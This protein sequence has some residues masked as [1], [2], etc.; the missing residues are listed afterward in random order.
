MKIFILKPSSLGDIVQ[1]LPVLRLLKL[2]I[3]QSQIY[4]WVDTRF[5]SI[6][7]GDKDL[8]GVIYFDR[9]HW[10]SPYYWGEV[11][12]SILN[13]RKERFD[14]VIDLQGLL[15]SGAFAW[16]ANGELLIGV[17]E[18]REGA[19]GFYDIAVRRPSY[20]THAVDWYLEV[21]KVLDIPVHF[22]FDWLPIRPE[23]A[24]SIKEKWIADSR[25]VVICPGG[26][27]K[28]KRW[29]DQNY[30]SLAKR[31]A[32]EDSDITFVII[33][34]NECFE[35]GEKIREVL[36]DRCINL[37]GKT[38]IPEMIEVIRFSQYVVSNDTGPMHIAAALKKP[39]VAIFGPT[40]PKRTGP[41]GFLQGVVQAS[42]PC[43]PCFKR[44]CKNPNQ[45]ECLRL[46]TTE[47]VIEKIHQLKSTGFIS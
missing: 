31:L 4:W 28:T 33:G 2:H 10:A 7:K 8:D 32:D 34:V 5:S 40:E 14:L 9:Y 29:F 23:I 16:I 1:A 45:L 46:V 13:V 17:D 47:T 24:D 36:K 38:T 22:N 18:P 25:Y 43:V 3:P 35:V 42:L 21:L 11:A 27:W 6:L 41:Y 20:Y 19:N 37:A 39:T 26:R 12:R 44:K 15:R 30:I